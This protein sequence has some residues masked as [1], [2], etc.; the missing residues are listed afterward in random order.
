MLY[1]LDTDTCVYCLNRAPGFERVL[2]RLGKLRFGDVLISAITLAE[3]EHG[4]A[5]RARPDRNRRLAEQFLLR[6][7]I[8]PFDDAAARAYGVLRAD[9]ERRGRPIGPFDT[10]IGAH[11]VSL[12]AVLVTNNTREFARIGGLRL[13]NWVDVAQ[14]P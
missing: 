4:L 11:A 6:F 12:R 5:K 2:D 7:E 1:L 8:A 3:L 9:L 10:L 13:Q 14:K